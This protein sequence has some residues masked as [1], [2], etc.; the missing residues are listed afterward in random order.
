MLALDACPAAAPA[1]WLVWFVSEHD[2]GAAWNVK[3]ALAT[4]DAETTGWGLRVVHAAPSAPAAEAVLAALPARCR[5][6]A[7]VAS[8]ERF[9]LKGRVDFKLISCL[10]KTRAYY[11]GIGAGPLLVAGG[12]DVIVRRPP[13][14][15]E[16]NETFLGAPWAWCDYGGKAPRTCQRVACFCGGNGG[17]SLR[18]PAFVA[19]RAP[20]GVLLWR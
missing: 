4:L 19:S 12:D 11:E 9:G 2:A 17:F 14:A 6:R 3:L 5:A 20:R 13:S 10:W 8:L 1:R 18:S 16:L 15:A 7:D